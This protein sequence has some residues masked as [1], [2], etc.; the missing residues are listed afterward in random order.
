M[1][2]ETKPK[3]RGGL[4]RD[5]VTG[6]ILPGPGAPKGTKQKPRP[7]QRVAAEKARKEVEGLLG[8]SMDIVKEALKA[9]KPDPKDAN[10]TIP[11]MQTRRETARFL[12][13]K[14]GSPT[15]AKTY[16][17]VQLSTVLEQY[18]DLQQVS[19]EA[20]LMAMDG[21]MS[22]EQVEHLQ[23]LLTAHAGIAGYMEIKDLREELERLA[24]MRT[25]SGDRLVPE[26]SRLSW[27]HGATHSG[28]D[29]DNP[30]E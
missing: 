5:P 9:T 25:I 7:L 24:N 12:L 29:R 23:R 20:I 16:I 21:L 15:P 3:K 28:N 11:D 19:H 18:D 4:P 2:E 14:F 1:T 6:K 27:G 26:E 10:K 8:E 30:A 13:G 17:E 22:F